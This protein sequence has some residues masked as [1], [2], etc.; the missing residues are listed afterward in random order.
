MDDRKRLVRMMDD[1][2][3]ADEPKFEDALCELEQIVRDLEDGQIDL[4]ESLA[5]YERGVALLRRCY[6]QL[7]DAEQ[8][9]LQLTGAGEDGEPILRPFVHA[10]SADTDDALGLIQYLDLKTYLVGDINTKVDRASMAHSLEV[11]EPLYLACAHV[12]VDTGA[13]SAAALAGRVATA[14]R[15]HTGSPA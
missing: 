15:D 11:R 9:I 8:R 14:L 1:K 12:V 10:A 4:E 7:R 6:G 5:R 13:Q 3:P 2:P